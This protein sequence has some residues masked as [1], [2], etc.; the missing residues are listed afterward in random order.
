M[1][2]IDRNDE[3][4]PVVKSGTDILPSIVDA[5]GILPD[6][7][8]NVQILLCLEG[9]TDVVAF[10]SFSRCLRTKYPEIVDLENDNRVLLVTLG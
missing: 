4:L 3:D 6:S 10:K 9:P 7:N 1:R 2:F 8:Q 5:L